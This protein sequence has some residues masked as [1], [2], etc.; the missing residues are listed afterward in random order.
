MT[1]EQTLQALKEILQTINPKQDLDAVGPDTLLVEGLGLDSLTLLLMSIS[2]EARFGIRIAPGT[3][4][5][6]VSDVLD[7]IVGENGGQ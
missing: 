3:T 6:R 4:F 7:Y 2:I 1:E 5:T